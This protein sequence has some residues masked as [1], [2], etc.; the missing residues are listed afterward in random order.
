MLNTLVTLSCDTVAAVSEPATP[1][2]DTPLLMFVPTRFASPLIVCLPVR[3]VPAAISW[4]E[5]VGVK[6]A[7]PL[8][9]TEAVRLTELFPA[10]PL[11]T[12][13]ADTVGVTD[14]VLESVRVFVPVLTVAEVPLMLAGA[15]AEPEATA[16]VACEA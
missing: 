1:K 13:P 4:L 2:I 11:A 5:V 16:L 8:V 6:V 14:M 12:Y 15:V 9:V 3:Y 10:V 7:A